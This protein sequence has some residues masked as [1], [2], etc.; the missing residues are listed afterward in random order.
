MNKTIPL[1]CLCD[2]K[3]KLRFKNG[4]YTCTDGRCVHSEV[5]NAFG[6]IGQTPIIISELLTDTVCSATAAQTYVKRTSQRFAGLKKFLNYT[7]PIT[8]ENC[9]QFIQL[10]KSIS[11]T[12][13]VLIIGGAERGSGTEALWGNQDIE[14]H[15]V[16]VYKSDNVDVI[17]DGHYLPLESQF[18]DGVWIQAVLEHV[19]EPNVVV[20]E[21]HRVLKEDG[22]VY[23]ETPFMQQVHEGAY[24]FTRYTV[25]GHRYLFKN[26]EQI[27]IGGNKGAGTVLAWSL[28][29]LALGLFRNKLI[30]RLI[31]L[32]FGLVLRPLDKLVSKEA[33]FDSPSG[34]FFMG[35]KTAGFRVKHRDLV[36]LYRGQC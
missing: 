11:E 4:V 17:C 22:V 18:Y 3:S 34:V 35:K 30:A 8:K 13:R 20:G 1:T 2:N 15:S 21:I 24:D 16:D 5:V 29:Y 33:M 14:I 19:V 32:V 27:S 31:G 26:F 23:A 36:N 9:L 25:L 10:V 28:R 6:T 12:P 7:S